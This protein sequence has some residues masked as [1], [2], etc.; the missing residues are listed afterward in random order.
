MRTVL[1]TGATGFIGSN[2]CL[3]LLHNGDRVIGL[4]NFYSSQRARLQGLEVFESFS[5]IEHDVRLS[6]NF[7]EK[8]D[9][10]YHLACPGRHPL[11]QIIKD[12]VFVMQTNANG[13]INIVEVA[14]EHQAKLLYTSTA[15]VYGIPDMIPTPET[16]WGITNP[17]GAR[18][19]YDESKRFCDAY[20]K[21]ARDKWPID[22]KIVRVFNCYGPFM[23][24]FEGR[25]IP[26][27]IMQALRQESLT[28]YGNGDQT[29][30]FCYVED[31]IRGFF[32][33][34]GMNHDFWGPVN[35]GNPQ[36]VTIKNLAEI[37]LEMTGSNSIISHEYAVP[38]DDPPARIPDIRLAENT[39]GWH[40]E[41]DLK[42]GLKKTVDY[43][44]NILKL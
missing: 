8:I 40:P 25:V 29:R 26:A 32:Q 33:V 13:I 44:R 14:R 18:S 10:I 30:S 35:I 22:I 12:P 2:L 17:V 23:D 21:A 4:D 9:D 28:V 11:H 27:F 38:T 24:D 41:I 15:E 43:Y 5:F 7:N 42:E 34:M 3:R 36:P 31:T 19:S 20:C 6:M 1:V 16:N 39:F 37:I